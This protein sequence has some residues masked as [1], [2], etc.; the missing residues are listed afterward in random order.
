MGSYRCESYHVV[1]E[2]FLPTFEASLMIPHVVIFAGV[3][4]HQG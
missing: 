4:M 3:E 1:H 2:K